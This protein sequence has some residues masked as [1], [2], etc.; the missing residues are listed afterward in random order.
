VAVAKVGTR[1]PRWDEQRRRAECRDWSVKAL[2]MFGI[3]TVAAGRVCEAGNAA[4]LLVA[5][6]TSWLDIYVVLSHV[7]AVFVAKKEV[8]SWP[9]IGWLAERLG[10]LFLDRTKKQSLVLTL[11]QMAGLLAS[12]RTVG[13]FPEGTTSDGTVV[14]PFHAPL[15]DAALRAGRPVQPVAIRYL[16]ASGGRADEVA[17]I[18]EMTLIESFQ[19]LADCRGYV[20]E[21]TF[22][23]PIEP[24]GRSRQ[25]IA[26][27]AEDAI[28]RHIELP[29][30]A[31]AASRTGALRIAA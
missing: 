29:L 17:F 3:R 2:D 19:R 28:R 20:A 31:A 8:R 4:P 22:L 11:N 14:L 26:R 6:H 24:T 21:I 1:W 10:A 12:G 30:D 9:A 18:G 15:F 27:L 16:N 25:E 7:D 13:L 5:N 23:D